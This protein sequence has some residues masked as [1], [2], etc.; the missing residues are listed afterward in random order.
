MYYY[1]VNPAAGNGQ[2]DSIQEKLKITLHEL[3]ID[4]E[5]AKTIGP[6]DGRNIA[7]KAINKGFKT[8]VAVGGNST[9]GEVVQAVYDSKKPQVAVGVIPIGKQNNLASRLGIASWKEACEVLALRRL[10]EYS[11]LQV[12]DRVFLDS[13]NLSLPAAEAAEEPGK[14]WL[15]KLTHG[16]D[17]PQ[18]FEY[19]L[20]VDRRYKVRG[21]ANQVII[22]NQKFHNPALDNQLLAQIFSTTQPAGFGFSRLLHLSETSFSQLHGNRFG[23]RSQGQLAAEVDGQSFAAKF[24]EV[25]LTDQPIKLISSLESLTVAAA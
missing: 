15:G 8:I 3:G 10:A 19:K 7:A 5:F 6:D 21:M 24:F 22:S 14:S 2:I 12:N 23:L 11:L 1:I 25:A 4:G 16:S 18:G 17:K 13:L 9:V 20:E